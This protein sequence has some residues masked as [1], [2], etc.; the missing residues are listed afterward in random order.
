[1]N[2]RFDS[3]ASVDLRAID[4]LVDGELS[5]G[6]ERSLL[7]VLEFQPDGWRRCALAFLEA[8]ALKAELAAVTHGDSEPL[9]GKP[10]KL[11]L[12]ADNKAGAPA[13]A[14]VARRSWSA[15]LS[16]AT[17]IGLAFFLGIVAHRHWNGALHNQLSVITDEHGAARDP[18]SRGTD[19]NAVSGSDLAAAQSTITMSLV[20]NRG[21]IERQLEIPVVE[22]DSFDPRWLQGPPSAIP[23]KLADA[24]R[25]NGHIVEEQR[26]FVPVRL[27]DGRQAIIPFDQA[28]VRFA[29]T[30]Y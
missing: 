2:E 5:A 27:D 3:A 12:P 23:Q 11:L 9:N 13:T 22:T 1:M 18:A 25:R 4:R 26:L 28:E 29:G 10:V 16:I 6:E 21:D 24:L 19:T 17:S 14:P 15:A 7:A 8:R 20:D 30:S